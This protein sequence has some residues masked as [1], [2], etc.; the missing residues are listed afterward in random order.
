MAATDSGK[1]ASLASDASKSTGK[2]AAELRR[3]AA[4]A[5][6][7]AATEAQFV[8]NDLNGGIKRAEADGKLDAAAVMQAWASTWRKAQEISER[9]SK[10]ADQL[11][12]EQP[13]NRGDEVSQENKGW[14]FWK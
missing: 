4:T 14:R 7:L 1:A 13:P 11:Q 9:L 6:Q 3:S 10:L 8:M 5:A 2:K 12:V